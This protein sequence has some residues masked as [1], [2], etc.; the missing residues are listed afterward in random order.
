MVLCVLLKEK[1]KILSKK[2]GKFSYGEKNS[3][4]DP[5]NEIWRKAIF[6]SNLCDCLM[7]Y[8]T[9]YDWQVFLFISERFEDFSSPKAIT[10]SPFNEE[11][12]SHLTFYWL[13]QVWW[14][15]HTEKVTFGVDF[16]LFA[17]IILGCPVLLM[18]QKLIN[19]FC[20]LQYYDWF[21]FKIKS[22]YTRQ[23]IWI[24]LFNLDIIIELA[25]WLCFSYEGWL[26]L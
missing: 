9:C 17:N 11:V 7:K 12:L 26:V 15:E 8:G 4:E 14:N 10:N 2:L 20:K 22:V 1:H 13:C 3:G 18:S 16:W 21:L 23:L 25:I 24:V 19:C 6:L 5:W